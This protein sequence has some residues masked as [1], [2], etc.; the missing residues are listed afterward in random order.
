[1]KLEDAIYFV[2]T[3]GGLSFIPDRTVKRMYGYSKMSCVDY[4]KTPS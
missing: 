1:M 3:I 4:E 2:Q